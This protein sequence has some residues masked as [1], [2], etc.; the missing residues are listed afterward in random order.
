MKL[1]ES[2]FAVCL[3][4]FFLQMK[5]LML[6]LMQ[7]CWQPVVRVAPKKK[8]WRNRLNLKEEMLNVIV[9]YVEVKSVPFMFD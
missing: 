5:Y 4:S 9:T 3:C 7:D 6:K 1:T 8:S 2:D